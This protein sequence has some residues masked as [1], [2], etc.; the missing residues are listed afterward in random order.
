MTHA[1]PLL[2]SDTFSHSSAPKQDTQLK[3]AW[4]RDALRAAATESESDRNQRDAARSRHTHTN[5]RSTTIKYE[6]FTVVVLV[7]QLNRKRDLSRAS[8]G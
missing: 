2:K 4:R 6:D 3:T 1:L 8:K 5:T 7:L